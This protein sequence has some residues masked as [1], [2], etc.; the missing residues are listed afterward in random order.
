MKLLHLLLIVLMVVS[1]GTSAQWYDPNTRK[2]VPDSE[3]R[4]KTSDFAVMLIVTDNMKAF[5]DKWYGTKESHAPQIDPVSKVQRGETVGAFLFFS[6]CGNEGGQ[7]NATADFKV[8]SPDGSIYGEHNGLSMWQGPA[9]KITLVLLSQAHLQI[10]IEPH[11]PYGV[12]IV[13]VKI[14]DPM[15]PEPIELKQRF[16]VAP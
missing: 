6:G 14:R 9:A 7:C 13:T 5:L 1:L 2:P 11:D 3:W 4:K 12:Y 10:G 8:F 16:E 15:L